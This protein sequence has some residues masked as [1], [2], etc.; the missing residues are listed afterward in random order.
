M[1][2]EAQKY[3]CIGAG[4][5]GSIWTPGNIDWVIK[6]EDGGNRGR[7]V[8]NDQL[9]HRR[10]IAAAIERDGGKLGHRQ[11][12]P[13]C[14]PRSM[15]IIEAE[16]EWWTTHIKHFPDSRTACRAYFQERIPAVPLQIR[17]LLIGRY[18]PKAIQATTRSSRENKD[19][20][21]RLYTGKRRRQGRPPTFFNLRNYGLHIDQMHELGLDTGAIVK[22]L[23]EALAHCYW[24]AHVDANDVE[25]VFA[26]PASTHSSP[27]TFNLACLYQGL[28]IWMLDYDCVRDMQQSDEGVRR[29]VHAFY[30]NDSYFPRPHFYG[31][32]QDDVRLWGV[33]RKCFLEVSEG[34]LGDR[35]LADVWVRL[36]EDE[37]RRRAANDGAC[38]CSK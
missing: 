29:A 19:C 14:V 32:A 30:Q 8:A 1:D 7:S 26:P 22:I 36:V 34:I 31:H 6:C 5:C 33:F 24:R 21:I 18:C 17:D 23:A 3:R 11:E 28:V 13:F 25:F 27:P 20:L 37:G 12:L 2:T 16:D 38:V 10:V 9:M 4:C 15:E 35:G